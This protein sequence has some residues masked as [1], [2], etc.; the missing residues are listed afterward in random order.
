MNS[1]W[2][3]V[4]STEEGHICRPPPKELKIFIIF[5][6]CFSEGPIKYAA[7]GAAREDRGLLWAAV[8]C[9]RASW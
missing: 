1:E 4:N 8:G 7:L 5:L 2:N 6:G 3:E 9:D